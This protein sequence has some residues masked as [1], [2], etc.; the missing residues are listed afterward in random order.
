MTPQQR[1]TG[2]D[3][4]LIGRKFGKITVLEKLEERY[5]SPGGKK[6][7][8]WRCVCECGRE[9]ITTTNNLCMGHSS[10][11]G[12]VSYTQEVVNR[13]ALGNVRENAGMVEVY[14]SYRRNARKRGLE[15]SISID[16]AERLFR[17]KCY[18]CLSEPKCVMQKK[19]RSIPFTY[20]GIDRKD[21]TLG[22]FEENCVSCC[23]VCNRIKYTLS[24]DEFLE[25]IKVIYKN[26]CRK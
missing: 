1:R 3:Y 16:F 21:N 22:Y 26:L 17:G 6:H 19:P 14:G 8:K 23:S 25:K 4:N 9:K 12:C 13:R 2:T 5:I 20:N 10:S 7:I 11:C 15:F 24:H 18:Y